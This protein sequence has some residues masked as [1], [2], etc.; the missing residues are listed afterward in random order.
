[1]H[2]WREY[3]DLN[4]SYVPVDLY[5]KGLSEAIERYKAGFTVKMVAS[6]TLPTGSAIEHPSGFRVDRKQVEVGVLS[7]SLAQMVQAGFG[8]ALHGTTSKVR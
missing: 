2:V 7:P 6:E 8:A 1:M 4:D 5:E 3:R